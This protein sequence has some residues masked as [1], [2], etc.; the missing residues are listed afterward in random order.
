MT[1]NPS[2]PQANGSLASDDWRRREINLA[3]VNSLKLGSSLLLTWGIALFTR[4]YIPRFLGPERFGTLN[5]ADAF[6]A[7]AFVAMGL[8]IDTYVRKEISVRPEHA[9]DFIGG[10]V[11][12]RI[13]LLAFVF[14]GMEIVMRAGHQSRDV[15]ILVYIYGFAQFFTVGGLTSA[16]L[17]QATG[18]VNE[19]SVLSVVIKVVW[20]ICIFVAIAF[21]LDLW[22]FALTVALTESA[23]SLILF[24]LARKHLRF[25]F[26]IQPRTTW[27]AIVAA[28]PFFVSGLAT[29]VYD[30]M[31]VNLLE[32]MTTRREVGWYGAASGFASMMLL[33]APLMSWVIIPLFARSAAESPD[34]LFRMV[35]RSMEFLLALATPVAMLMFAGADVWVA[36][37][38][39]KAFAPAA[40]S[41]RVLSIAT[42]LMYVSIVAAYALAVL[43]YTWRMSLTFVAGM[44][45]NPTVNL[46][47]IRQLS[48]V[49]GPGGGGLACATA[50]LVTEIAIVISL[51]SALGP[52]SF[53]R[54][55]IVASV[56]NLSAATLIVVVDFLFLKALGPWRLLVDAILYAALVLISGAFDFKGLLDIVRG[57]I[58]QR[59]LKRAGAA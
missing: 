39:G 49:V 33:F 50:T 16:G 27:L 3:F 55:L 43:N 37:A 5:F 42:F 36:V 2:S 48:T 22:A 59:R 17:L 38:F 11:A 54:R 51:L 45:I 23:K 12:L 10:V 24:G 21:R 34:E 4:L 7:T 30:K 26:R 1:E 13:I 28:L 14:A 57:A 31:G 47:L 9:S 15:R 18:K 20:A 53:D 8:G 44:V 46:L 56:K 52:R 19:M 25:T 58:Q 41:L 40:M 6:T 32:F 29:T 35:R